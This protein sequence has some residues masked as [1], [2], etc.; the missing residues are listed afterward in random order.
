M[1][2]NTSQTYECKVFDNGHL[3]QFDQTLS[4]SDKSVYSCAC[5]A[6]VIENEDAGTGA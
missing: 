4:G 1:D 3:M 5:G 6:T 2:G